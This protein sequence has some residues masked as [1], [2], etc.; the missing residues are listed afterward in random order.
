MKSQ[1][2]EAPSFNLDRLLDVDRMLDVDR[3]FA[4]DPSGDHPE[5]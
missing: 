2:L 3:L 1:R 5:T 4:A